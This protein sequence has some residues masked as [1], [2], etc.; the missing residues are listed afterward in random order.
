M[1][2]VRDNASVA[3]NSPV[4]LKCYEDV[5]KQARAATRRRAESR[6]FRYVRM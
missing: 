5:Y 1:L 3:R 6:K 2:I 4:A